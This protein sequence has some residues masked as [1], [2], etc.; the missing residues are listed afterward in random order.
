MKKITLVCATAALALSASNTLLGQAYV[1]AVNND[2]P[3]AYYRFNDTSSASDDTVTDEVGSNDGLYFRDAT[4]TANNSLA[5]FGAGNTAF[6]VSSADQNYARLGT[7]PGF[8]SS[9][10]T[11]VTIEFWVNSSKTTQGGMGLFQSNSPGFFINLDEHPSG[12]PVTDDNIRVYGQLSGNGAPATYGGVAAD[13]D[14]TDGTWNYFAATLTVNAG[15]DSIMNVY[16][17]NAGDTATTLLSSTILSDPTSGIAEDFSINFTVG[18]INV[19]SS[20]SFYMDGMFDELALYDSILT[21]EQLDAHVLASTVP[22]PSTYG[23][24]LGGAGLGFVLLRR[25]RV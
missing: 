20:A 18:V 7:L 16:T 25:R 22:E 13:T 8:G 4:L 2:N 21:K 15:G 1:T 5:G 10:D 9:L 3:F 12:S 17:A 6:T 24:L 23:I 11:G 14:I 19:N